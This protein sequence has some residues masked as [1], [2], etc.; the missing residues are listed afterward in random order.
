MK[1]YIL[2]ILLSTLFSQNYNNEDKIILLSGEVHKGEYI[3]QD[4]KF[5]VFSSVDYIGEQLIKKS[6]I[7]Q[8]ILAN[9][10]IIYNKNGYEYAASELITAGEEMIKFKKHFYS[11][12]ITSIIGAIPIIV[13][14]TSGQTN[15]TAIG[16]VAIITGNI[17]TILSFKKLSK[18]GEK[19]IDAGKLI[20]IEQQKSKWSV[21]QV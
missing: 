1:K 12:L 18:A 17:I 4:E 2:L 20:Q 5:V 3:S 15:L 16:Q 10:E 19:I 7:R 14:I 21:T 6:I 13:G 11:G 8:I 9:G